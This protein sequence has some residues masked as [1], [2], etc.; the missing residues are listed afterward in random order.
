MACAIIW[1]PNETAMTEVKPTT[2]V[3]FSQYRELLVKYLAP[4]RRGVTLLAVL[5][6]AN[7][8]LQLVG[9]QIL[10]HLIDSIQAGSA[11]GRLIAVALLFTGIALVQ[12]VVSVFEAYV[13]GKVSWTATNALRNDLARHA[14]SLDLS[15]HNRH[16][17]G[18][19][20]ERVDGDSETLGTFLST[21][22]IQ[23]VGSALLLI[24]ILVLLYCED[25]R[26]GLAL[27]AF[28]AVSFLVL[29][30]LR[31]LSDLH[32]RAT[33]E[34]SA[35]TFSFLE[36][37][38]SG[39]EDIRSSGAKPHVM[40]GFL[41]LIRKWYRK[42]L[43]AGL[44]LSVVLNSTFFMVGAGNAIAL[45]VG[46]YLYQGGWIT[47][48]TV[49]L[50]FHYAN[51][52]SG[53]IE[54]FTNQ[55]DTL[56]RATGSIYRV[57]ELTQARSRIVDGPGSA[58]PSGPLSVALDNVSFAYDGGDTVLKELQF[59][60][61][62][63]RTLGLLGRTGSGK[64]TLSRLLVRLCDPD[65]GAVRLGG[66]N[67]RQARV[68]ELR[69]RIG[70][71]TQNVQLFHGTVRDNLTF[72]DASVGDAQIMQV[73]GEV[74]L[75]EWLESLPEGLDTTLQAGGGGLSAGESQLLAF[76]RVF[77]GDAGLVILDEASSRLDR[78][79]EILV[80]NAIRRLVRDRTVLTIAHH[81]VTVQSVDEIMILQD[82]RIV[83]HGDRGALAG[84]RGSRF[85]GLLEK[86]L[87]EVLA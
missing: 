36:E 69:R 63:G 6:L 77:L 59:E 23:L 66:V 71:V 78:G 13:G 47:I 54:R 5:L 41:E 65:D 29:A 4:Q 68:A 80:Q 18:E 16:T 21:F 56:Q 75:G 48:G 87:E 22:V 14:L 79:T 37:R 7:V 38:L 39:T 82:G 15:F 1:C 44:M 74:G 28:A 11:L 73:I 30:R 46:A 8:G 32:W 12:Q 24:G 60:L 50:L 62:P 83:E 42:E 70:M 20:I 52:L 86:G 51:M 26:A 27:S 67:V 55:M 84:D 35:D 10:R 53:P 57:L 17:A 64:T 34:A 58:F 45:A 19:M 49:Y 9:P 33:R 81:L 85:H 76:S 3:P 31:N 43:K 2:K 61:Q 25:W 40:K 72:F